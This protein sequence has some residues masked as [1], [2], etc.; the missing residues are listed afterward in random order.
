MTLI[1]TVASR[2]HTILFADRRLTTA[3]TVVLEEEGKAGAVIFPEGRMLYG[4]TGI[5]NRYL[6]DSPLVAQQPV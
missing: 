6:R 5:A 4:F 1:L 2:E 3:G